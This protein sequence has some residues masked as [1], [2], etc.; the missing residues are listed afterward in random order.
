MC[1]AALWHRQTKRGGGTKSKKLSVEGLL[2]AVPFCSI[3]KLKLRIR[4]CCFLD[5]P[6]FLGPYF[7]FGFYIITNIQV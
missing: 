5:T 7:D 4:L 3:L 6:L 2:E 1:V